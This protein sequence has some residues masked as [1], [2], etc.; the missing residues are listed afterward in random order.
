M[1]PHQ[2]ELSKTPVDGGPVLGS[3][4]TLEVRFATTPA[5]I[6]AAQRLRFDIFYREMNAN[7]SPEMAAAGRDFDD[8][9]PICRH[10]LVVDKSANDQVIGTYRLMREDAA[11][12]SP[13]G[14]YTATEYDISAMLKARQGQRLLELGRSCVLKQFRT[15]PTMQLLW[16]G[17]FVYL[18]RHDVDLMFGCASLPGTDPKALALQLSYLHHFHLA[19]EGERVRALPD[20]YVP[21]DVMPKD[22]IDEAEALRSLPPLVKGYVRSGAKVGDG[23]VIDHQF[24]T[25][26]VCVYFP[27]AT[28]NPRVVSHLKKKI[29]AGTEG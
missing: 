7:P 1:S 25:T 20:R 9:D 4:G 18:I 26:D 2:A 15:G 12:K 24:G 21:M 22:A 11:T 5:E 16:R 6:E 27:V 19:P 23:A 29:A 3:S 17:L 28:V 8:F 14:F 10:L 13:L